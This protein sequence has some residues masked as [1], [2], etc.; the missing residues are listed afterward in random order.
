MSRNK[1]ASRGMSLQ[2][3][4]QYFSTIRHDKPISTLHSFVDYEIKMTA[5][6]FLVML[7]QKILFVTF[8]WWKK[9]NYITMKKAELIKDYRALPIN[10]YG[11]IAKVTK[12]MRS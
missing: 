3:A 5:V 2:L 7:Q 8:L 9:E 12:K 1:I 11:K 10:Y 6:T 4:M